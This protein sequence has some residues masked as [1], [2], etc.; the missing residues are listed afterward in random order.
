M[1]SA[2][3]VSRSASVLALLRSDQQRLFRR[4]QVRQIFARLRDQGARPY[5]ANLREV[6]ASTDVRYL[7]KD[8]I[9]AWLAS[10]DMPTAA[11]LTIVEE[12]C[13][14]GHPIESLGQL[15]ASGQSWLPLLIAKDTITRWI[16]Q[17]G[18]AKQ[19]ALWL[20]R[21]GAIDYH[22]RVAACLRHWWA[23]RKDRTAEIRDWFQGLYLNG[24]IGELEGLYTDVI[25]SISAEA[26][27][28]QFEANFDPAAWTHMDRPLGARLLGSW[29]QRWM[30]AFPAAHPFGSDEG[31]DGRDSL[32]ELAEHAPGSLLV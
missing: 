19:L 9:A 27:A 23:N 26:L 20:L 5:F 24:P 29:L 28:P 16:D 12:W 3:F 21:N 2:V 17:G 15:V 11:E 31:P 25:E 13:L 1:F 18:D 7:V 22:A 30:A 8:A 10:V 4:T 32:K 6:M 14:P